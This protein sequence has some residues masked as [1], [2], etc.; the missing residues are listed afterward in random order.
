MEWYKS[1]GPGQR[2]LCFPYSGPFIHLSLE[3]DSFEIVQRKVADLVKDKI[4]IGHALH[5]DLKALLLSHPKRLTRD[6][7]F[8]SYKAG[9]CKSNR[10]A[11]RV[12]VQQ[13]LDL[14][15]QSG[16][17]SSVRSFFQSLTISNS[18]RV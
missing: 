1:A 2:C 7:Q 13:E 16:E 12:L 6:T 10:V 14:T 17:H 11:L 3:A 4:I 18:E 8:Y 9:I 15:I 5:H